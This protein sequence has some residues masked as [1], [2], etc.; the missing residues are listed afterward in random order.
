M[1]RIDLIELADCFTPKEITDCIFKQCP[2]ITGPIPVED[3]A[4]QT[5]ILKIQPLAQPCKNIEGLMLSDD[6][7]SS[8]FIFYNDQRPIGRQRFSIAHEL[9]HFLMPTHSSSQNC[10][11]TDFQG[12]NS[13]EEKEANEFARLLLL[14]PHLLGRELENSPLDINLINQ[15][16]D[17]FQTSFE[18]TANACVSHSNEAVAI[19]YIKDHTVRYVWMNSRHFQV[20]LKVWKNDKVPLSYQNIDTLKHSVSGFREL[21]SNDWIASSTLGAIPRIFGQT[22][23]QD[24]GYSAVLLKL[25]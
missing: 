3:I 18:A 2:H 6:E 13:N 9:G 24:N 17:L 22:I 23:V 20:Q 25:F 8:G 19:A 15:I 16:S 4:Y 10:S 14:P 1:L 7:K 5:G 11:T 12:N 21:E